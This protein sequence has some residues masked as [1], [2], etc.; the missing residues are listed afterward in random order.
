MTTEQLNTARAEAWH[1]A[2][3]PLLTADDASSWLAETGICL[4]LP[5]GQ[6]LSTA[7]PSFVE[8]TLGTSNPTPGLPGIEEATRLLHRLVATGGIVALRLLGGPGDQPDF[9]A[10]SDTLPFLF[11]LVG[12]KEWKR[13]PRGKSSPL[14]IEV[15][16]LLDREG[17]LTAV[18]VKEKLGRQLTETAAARALGELWLNLRIEPVYRDGEATAWQ[19]LE[20][21]RQKQMQAGSTMS[22]AVALSALVSL[23][24]Q[25]A[26]AASSEEIEVFLSPLASRSKIRDVLKGLTATRQLGIL[27]LGPIEMFHLEGSLAEFPEIA[28]PEGA[29]VEATEAT[30][31]A[32][33]EPGG[34]GEGRRRFVASR[35]ADPAAS[36]PPAARPPRT[37]APREADKRP[38]KPQRSAPGKSTGDRKSGGARYGSPARPPRDQGDRRPFA[39]RP[40]AA[41]ASRP[42]AAGA[43]RKP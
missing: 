2:G 26:I 3:N 17:P 5:R 38:G 29:V 27:N 9:L 12:D 36:T 35:L 21:N 18:E 1:Q 34:I 11:A 15:W 37:A 10:T 13:G 30:S 20:R 19:L 14:V 32:A 8:A 31:G 41:A 16:K 28:R 40:P 43:P 6:Q 4:F 23:Y 25:S 39:P 7:A 33:G 24:L 22:Q 42:P